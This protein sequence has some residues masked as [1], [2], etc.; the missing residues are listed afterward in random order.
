MLI[1]KFLKISVIALC[2]IVSSNIQIQ[3]ASEPGLDVQAFMLARQGKYS[4]AIRLMDQTIKND[5]KNYMLYNTRAII[6]ENSG[7][8]NGALADYSYAISLNPSYDKAY[9]NRATLYVKTKQYS[10]ATND[11]NK[12]VSIKPSY[13]SY[14]TCGN[15]KLD[16]NLYSNAITNFTK[17]I[18]FVEK[19][20]AAFAKKVA[21][22]S[23]FG[24][25]NMSEF[26]G[27]YY[28]RGLAYYYIKN[29]DKAYSYFSMAI[30]CSPFNP[31][32]YYYIGIIKNQKAI[33]LMQ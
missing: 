9:Q 5:S 30:K 2:L 14:L 33:N 31:D 28:G 1:K 20:R 13:E 29:Y 24:T 3:A 26:E 16:S 15:I 4:S 18:T 27:A 12:L 23:A 17:A 32:A 22:G 21:E 11:C 7:D 8:I 19:E 25:M 10:S 6:K